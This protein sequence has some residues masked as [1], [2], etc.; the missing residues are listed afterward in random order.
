MQLKAQFKKAVVA[1]LLA[2]SLTGGGFSAAPQA[3]GAG[4]RDVF[5]AAAAPAEVSTAQI[6][7]WQNYIKDYPARR[8]AFDAAQTQR[9]QSA[10]AVTLTGG[11]SMAQLEKI[12]PFL[13][14]TFQSARAAQQA[15]GPGPAAQI[16]PLT[17][18]IKDGAGTRFLF[19]SLSGPLFC[20]AQELCTTGIYVN[21]GAGWTK[22]MDALTRGAVYAAESDG[23]L[24]LFGQPY[25]TGG[26]AMEWVLRGGKFQLNHPP[27]PYPATQ[28]FQKWQ[29]EHP[30]GQHRPAAAA[31]AAPSA[32]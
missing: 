12:Y 28:L 29:Q 17:A 30:S 7:T 14:D 13:H 32:P 19:L 16:T 31:N 8:A 23:H 18:E 15:V 3:Q 4:V 1:G 25:Q 27:D 6:A 20:G 11:K 2:L 21:H 22:A 9:W 24:S 26:Q 10:E 5:N